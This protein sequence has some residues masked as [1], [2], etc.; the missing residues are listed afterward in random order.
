MRELWG[1]VCFIAF[2]IGATL[3]YLLL[4]LVNTGQAHYKFLPRD[5]KVY[6]VKVKPRSKLLLADGMTFGRTVFI[7]GDELSAQG[8]EHEGTHVIDCTTMGWFPF[9]A[10]YGR[11]WALHGY[12]KNPY[13]IKARQRAGQPL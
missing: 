5:G 8:L 11:Q 13:E 3:Y 9:F 12:R 2:P 7:R 10:D 6:P 4:R 1:W